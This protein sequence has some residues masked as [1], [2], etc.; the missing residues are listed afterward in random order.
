[1]PFQTE[2]DLRWQEAV[3]RRLHEVWGATLHSFGPM[4]EVDGWVE[5][6]G[7]VWAVCEI[8]RRRVPADRY[9]TIWVALRKW[10]SLMMIGQGF[11]VPGLFIV[12]YDDGIKWIEAKDCVRYKVVI[13]GRDD[14]GVPNDHEPV[15]DVPV[16]ELHD[17]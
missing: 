3:G 2:T 16:G 12:H 11:G 17:L 4:D 5:R 1:M 7:E 15:I 10:T 6:K 8:K 13:G 9:P 14:R